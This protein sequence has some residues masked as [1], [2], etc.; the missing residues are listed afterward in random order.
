MH[1]SGHVGISLTLW[2]VPGYLLVAGG[3]LRLAAVTAAVVIA[4][5]VLPD[6]DEYL[7]IAHRGVTHTVWFVVGTGVG[8]G[9]IVYAFAP[10]VGGGATLLIAGAATLSS[11]SHVWVD[12][13]TPMGIW[14]FRP[15]VDRHYSMG[16]VRS[17]D[18]R[19]N[20]LFAF[21]GLV[22]WVPVVLTALLG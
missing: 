12:S 9:A 4:F 22:L 14:P 13:L 21:V 8:T 5:G 16:I 19:A 1:V 17:R 6:I 10:G 20:V 2:A 18:R 15:V 7:P 11:A 3:Q